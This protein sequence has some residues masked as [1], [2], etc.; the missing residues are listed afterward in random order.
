M[1]QSEQE[2]QSSLEGSE[3]A[4]SSADAP[5]AAAA[6][7]APVQDPVVPPTDQEPAGAEEVQT[8]PVGQSEEKGSEPSKDEGVEPVIRRPNTAE[9]KAFEEVLAQSEGPEAKLQ[10]ITDFMATSLAR[11]NMPDFRCFWEAR[12]LCL[13]L[14]KERI[15]AAVRAELWERYSEL[16]KEARRLKEMLDEQAAFA[17]EQIDMAVSALEKE[18]A[19]AEAD[20]E[21]LPNIE[22]GVDSQVMLERFDFYNRI[23]RQLNLLNAQASRINALRKE[24]IRTEKRI[25]QKNK[26][27]QRLSAAG[28]LVFPLRKQLIKEISDAFIA[29]VAAYVKA[30]FKGARVEGAIFEHRQEIKAL[31]GVA[32]TLT[33]NTQ[34]FTETRTQL[35]SCWDILRDLDKE[36]RKV[37]N[38]KRAEF[39]AN[40]ELIQK[41]LDA[42]LEEWTDGKLSGDEADKRLGQIS[43]H[44]RR[45][46][47]GRD[48]VKA[49]RGA[50]SAAR[51][52]VEEKLE[53]QEAE[54]RQRE[55]EKR[56]K[57]QQRVQEMQARIDAV[58][59]AAQEQGAEDV[60]ATRTQVLKEIAESGLGKAEQARL[61]RLLR[62]LKDLIVEKREQALLSL[63]ADDQQSL[64]QLRQL[65]KERRQR[66][67]EI[68]LALDQ[69]RKAQGASGFDFEQALAA[70]EQ[71]KE[72]RAR[73]EK[74]TSGI[75]DVE[76]R[77]RELEAKVGA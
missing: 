61:E 39:Q 1:S 73:L 44:M 70:E 2:Q 24:L 53:A 55:E 48:E 34:A 50:L 47:L 12:K 19:A 31:Q 75:S 6:A 45:V 32:K 30:N 26:F 9:W 42:F 77:I 23:Q 38:E 7:E 29:D 49:L 18:L 28:D 71:I 37:R 14:F 15:T 51:K 63:S 20:L 46:E 76:S 69:A 11:P 40:Q 74:V 52:P 56:A 21:S 72:E 22:L 62:P 64:Q 25:R 59:S 16:S 36:R 67:A 4:P 58:L 65:L 5:K 33:L 35:S 57:Q 3:L 41:E 17:V 68:K 43:S 54:R 66:R 27:F 8:E 10:T 13:P 60:E